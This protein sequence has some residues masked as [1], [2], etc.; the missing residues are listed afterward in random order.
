MKDLTQKQKDDLV[1]TSYMIGCTL[2][3]QP[4]KVIGRLMQFPMVVERDGPLAVE[5]SWQ[6][7]ARVMAKDRAFRA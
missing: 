5:Y 7:V 3:G 4:A 1:L 2:N 6:A